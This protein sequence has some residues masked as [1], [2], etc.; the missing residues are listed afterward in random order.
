[1]RKFAVLTRA[2]N[3]E[4]H[5]RNIPEVGDNQVLNKQETCN[6]C[7]TDYGQWLGL[8]EHQPYPMAGGHE[9]SGVIVRKGKNVREELNIGDHVALAYDYCGECKSCQIGKTSE[10]KE[11]LDRKSVV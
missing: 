10:C 1:M 7:T 5:E 2:K 4:V 8:R 9:G 6:I 11:V 3:A